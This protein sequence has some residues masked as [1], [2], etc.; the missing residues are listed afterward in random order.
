MFDGELEWMVGEGDRRRLV[1]FHAPSLP[2]S[3]LLTV[4]H[5]LAIKIK[6]SRYNFHQEITEH[7]LSNLCLLCRLQ[8]C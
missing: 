7:L 1:N 3:F 2:P 6:D 5:P 8:K 4:P